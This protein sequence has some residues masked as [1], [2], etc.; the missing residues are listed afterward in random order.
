MGWRF[1]PQRLEESLRV[2]L[3]T[4]ML[5]NISLDLSINM[6]LTIFCLIYIKR[7][8][9]YISNASEDIYQRV[10]LIYIKRKIGE[11]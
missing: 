6:C 9:R 3:Y 4:M 10:C 11:E 1:L 2:T 7:G 5:S 8:V